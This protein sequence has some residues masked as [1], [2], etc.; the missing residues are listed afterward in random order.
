MDS[1]T[2]TKNIDIKYFGTHQR[3]NKKS[4]YL[5]FNSYHQKNFPTLKLINSFTGRNGPDGDWMRKI[6]KDSNHYYNPINNTGD[7]I[8]ICNE[9]YQKAL[10][11][12]TNKHMINSAKE[13]AYMAHYA[14]DALSPFHHYGKHIQNVED[15]ENWFDPYYDCGILSK[16]HL[17]V[18][19]TFFVKNLIKEFP[20][21]QIYTINNTEKFIK[22]FASNIFSLKIVERY[23]TG[24]K[25]DADILTYTKVIP[26]MISVV[27]SLYRHLY[28]ESDKT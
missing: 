13:I 22:R 25:R 12:L 5:A 3:I 17:K 2:L 20:S 19:A 15:Y 27:A 6:D 11:H 10:F 14:I 18:E 7:A 21:G 26:S 8:S 1:G 16:K 23:K 24:N 9:K 4:Y 28:C